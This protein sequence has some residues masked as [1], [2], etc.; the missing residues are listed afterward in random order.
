MA[1]KR[2]LAS[3]KKLGTGNAPRGRA[4]DDNWRE[5]FDPFG[6]EDDA[7]MIRRLARQIE[8]IAAEAR[9]IA[10]RC[11]ERLGVPRP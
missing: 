7:L 2:P 11:V 10:D 8:E 3:A 4:F 6:P 5:A 9:R 1:T